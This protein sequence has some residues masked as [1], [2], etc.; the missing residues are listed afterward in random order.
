MILT[1]TSHVDAATGVG[2]SA[3]RC[4][5]SYVVA[6]RERALQGCVSFLP[7]T[8]PCMPS[9]DARFPRNLVTSQSGLLSYSHAY[10]DLYFPIVIPDPRFTFISLSHAD[11]LKASAILTT[12]VFYRSD[13]GDRHPRASLIRQGNNGGSSTF[14]WHQILLN[15]GQG[16]ETTIWGL[17]REQR[18]SENCRNPFR[19]LWPMSSDRSCSAASLNIPEGGSNSFFR[20]AITMKR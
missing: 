17:L 1:L 10:L 9:H 14:A 7:Q 11:T 8:A 18:D 3:D 5:C 6:R 13:L 2:S 16:R 12:Q 4:T 20:A 15:N 19:P